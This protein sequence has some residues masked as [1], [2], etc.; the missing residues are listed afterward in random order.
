MIRISTVIWLILS[1]V[2]GALL[3]NFSQKT[4][5]ER[6]RIARLERNLE[7]EAQTIAVLEAEWSY[8][9]RPARLRVLAERHLHLAPVKRVT[10]VDEGLLTFFA[11]PPETLPEDSPEDIGR[12]LHELT[13]ETKAE[14]NAPAALLAAQPATPPLP[15]FRTA[16]ARPHL[17]E[18]PAAVLQEP[19]TMTDGYPVPAQN[20]ADAARTPP[21]AQDVPIRSFEDLLSTIANH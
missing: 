19:V 2:T 10:V 21:A 18:S 20:S 1:I 13:A 15:T 16:T 17:T 12:F 7:A 6:H 4:E 5:D 9:N 3:L 11:P 8:L 14:T